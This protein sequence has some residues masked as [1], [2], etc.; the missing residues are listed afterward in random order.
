MAKNREQRKNSLN[1]KLESI[2][3]INA[4]SENLK[5]TEFL[6]KICDSVMFINPKQ[7][8]KQLENHLISK[9]HRNLT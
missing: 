7:G 9:K 5:D 4:C 6:C 8:V 1:K 3:E 2:L